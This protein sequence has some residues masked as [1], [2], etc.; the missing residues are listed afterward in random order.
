MEKYNKMKKAYLCIV[1]TALTSLFPV[2]AVE[3]N[4]N[5]IYREIDI[6]FITKSEGAL[7][8]ILRSTTTDPNY[9]LLENY[10]LKK[11]RRMINEEEY[12]FALQADLIL[13]DNDMDYE[14]ALDLYQVVTEE[15]EKVYAVRKAEEERIKAEKKRIAEEK[16]QKRM[17]ASKDYKVVTSDEGK[18]TFVK[19]EKKEIKVY[20]DNY[21]NIRVNLVDLNFITS[22]IIPNPQSNALGST[23]WSYDPEDGERKSEA[24]SNTGTYTYFAPRYGIGIDATYERTMNSLMLGADISGEVFLISFKEAKTIGALADG[25]YGSDLLNATSI[26]NWYKY[27]NNNGMEAIADESFLLNASAALKVGFTANEKLFYLRMGAA[28]YYNSLDTKEAIVAKIANAQDYK[29]FQETY[30]ELIAKGLEDPNDYYAIVLNPSC[31][32]PTVGFGIDRFNVGPLTLSGDLD[33]NVF[34]FISAF[35]GKRWLDNNT[36]S[37][38]NISIN[39]SVP[40]AEMTNSRVTFNFGLKDTLFVKRTGDIENRARLILAFGVENVTK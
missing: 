18:K 20:N 22:T 38:A 12:E 4:L 39:A 6:A 14:P 9:H 15:L 16:E 33:F 27:S 40:L 28:I 19:K 25:A 17:E 35:K 24:G 26:W 21:W 37:L 2:F 29:D 11:I 32:S 10:T 34:G 8:R 30:D 36:N 31:F 1:L 7:N 5:D 23:F 13:L 3:N